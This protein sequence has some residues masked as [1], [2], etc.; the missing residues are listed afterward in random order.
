M[1]VSCLHFVSKLK[2]EAVPRTS[3]AGAFEQFSRGVSPYGPYWN[4]VLG[5]WKASIEWPERVFF[6]RYEDL[7]KE[8]CFHTKRLAEFLGHP[9]TTDAE[10]ENLV[11]KVARVL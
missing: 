2:P 6:L 7:K 8:P 4:H 11:N 9:F 5:Y 1:L 10:G 3:L